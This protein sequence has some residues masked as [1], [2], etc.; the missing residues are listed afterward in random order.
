MMQSHYKI[1]EAPTGGDPANICLFKLNNK[2]PR[3]RCEICSKLTI[4]TSERCQRRQSVS[5]VDFEQVNVSWGA[6]LENFDA[7][8]Y[9]FH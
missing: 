4:K 8:L 3:K 7:C 2:N 9:E 6:L 5:L 1:S